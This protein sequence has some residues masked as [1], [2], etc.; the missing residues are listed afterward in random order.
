[1]RSN[2]LTTLKIGEWKV[3]DNAYCADCGAA[4]GSTYRQPWRQV[5]LCESCWMIDTAASDEEEP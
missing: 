5:V 2:S 4:D 3:A 1:M